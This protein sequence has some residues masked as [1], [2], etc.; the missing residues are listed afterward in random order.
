MSKVLAVA[1]I[2]LLFGVADAPAQ[3]SAAG[4]KMQPTVKSNVANYRYRRSHRAWYA[5]YR[6]RYTRGGDRLIG[7][8]PYPERLTP[9]GVLTGP[10]P[11]SAHGG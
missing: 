7:R 4:V 3:E 1:A 11:R 6:W 8:G 9:G 10:I 5:P 2:G